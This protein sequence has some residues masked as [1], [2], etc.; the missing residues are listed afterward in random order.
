ML[1]L[2]SAL[3]WLER[4]QLR[5]QLLRRDEKVLADIGVSRD[6]L[7]QGVRAWP[8]KA[9][10]D[11]VWGLAPFKLDGIDDGD[12]EAAIAELERYDDADLWDLGL[13]R[14]TIAEAVRHGRPGFPE[15]QRRAA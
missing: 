1:S 4:S 14:G 6:L 2:S 5:K 11:P 9:P 10:V 15:E 8:W 7:L 12:Y 13:T 3:V